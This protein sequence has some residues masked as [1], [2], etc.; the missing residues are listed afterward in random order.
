MKFLFLL[1]NF[2]FSSAIYTEVLQ[3]VSILL[4]AGAI[5]VLG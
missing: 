1:K 2:F 3:A 4:G 5:F